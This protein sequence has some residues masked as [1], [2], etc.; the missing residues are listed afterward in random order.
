VK[1]QKVAGL[2]EDLLFNTQQ[3]IMAIANGHI[4]EAEKLMAAKQDELLRKI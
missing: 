4:E 3:Q 2:S 1:K